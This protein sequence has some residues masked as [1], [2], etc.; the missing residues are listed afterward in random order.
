MVEIAKAFRSDLSVLILDEP[1]ASLTDPE[2]EQLFALIRR[3]TRMGVGII[4]ITHRMAEIRR[5]AD[6]VTVLR[7]A[8]H[9]AT[10]K[11]ANADDDT[12]VRL[13]TGRAAGAIFS[14]TSVGRPWREESWN[15]RMSRP[16]MA[17]SAM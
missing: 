16:P 15:L 6:R 13:M 1:T 3:L 4:Y 11:V 7:D 2:A 5:I 12:L 9:V 14:G 17:L 8:R 10:L